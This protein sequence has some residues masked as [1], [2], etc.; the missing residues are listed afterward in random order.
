[1]TLL[2]CPIPGTREKHTHFGV[3]YGRSTRI[4]TFRMLSEFGIGAFT[5]LHA[6]R[7]LIVDAPQVTTDAMQAS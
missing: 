5:G 3:F 7:E 2:R 4:K 6:V 1:M